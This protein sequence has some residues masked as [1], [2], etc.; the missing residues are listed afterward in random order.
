[1]P[2]DRRPHLPDD[3]TARI[4]SSRTGIF[5]GRALRLWTLHPRWSMALKASVAAGIAWYVGLLA[6]APFAEYP[7]YAPLGAVIATSSTVARSVR[8]TAQTVAAILLGVLVA[9]LADAFLP[10]AAPSIAL[11]V[12]VATV[13]AGWR[14]FGEMGV[15]VITTALFVLVIGSANPEAFVGAY[16]GLVTAGA[17]VGLAVNLAFPPLP[18]T[19][20]DAALDGLRDTL[21]DQLDALADGL[22]GD[23]PPTPGEWDERRYAIGPVREKARAAVAYAAEASRGNWHARRYSAWSVAQAR[24]SQ[25][26]ESH[27]T[28]VDHLTSLL[29]ET[30]R[31][32]V[33]DPALGPDLRPAAADALAEYAAALRA[34]EASTDEDVPD[35]PTA[36]AEAVDRLRHEVRD[37]RTRR[38]GDFLAAGAIVLALDR[39]VRAVGADADSERTVEA[40]EQE[41]DGD[42]GT[43][44]DEGTTND[45]G[46][47]DVEG[48]LDDR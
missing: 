23:R 1:M 19:P 36:L 43:A 48:T 47:E 27:A 24:R 22:R 40:A 37:Q 21:A 17:L 16:A 35:P 29:T 39:A 44:D 38:E 14:L 11:V 20:S 34:L 25:M 12:G 18:L 13:A 45:E 42:E 3:L 32:D 41:A 26:L 46:V 10:P 4:R 15:Y 2:S 30:E 8:E 28:V 5:T 6:P 33:R 31:D 7:Y 9:R